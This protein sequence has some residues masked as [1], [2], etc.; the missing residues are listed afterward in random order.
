MDDIPDTYSIENV[1]QMRAIADR[2]RV[3]I[4]ELLAHR[5]MTVAQLSEQLHL[6]HAKVHYHVRELE[7]VGLVRLVETR[8]KGGILE[9][10]YRTVA[11]T[12]T[13]SPNL[14]SRGARDETVEIASQL[15]GKLTASFLRAL[16]RWMAKKEGDTTL[17]GIDASSLFL[18]EEEVSDLSR[19][20]N[21]L[22]EPYA[23]PRGIEGEREVTLVRLLFT[24]DDVEDEPAVAPSGADSVST[25]AE[26][27]Q[28]TERTPP[29]VPMPPVRDRKRVHTAITVGI[30]EYSRAD[31]EGFAA[32]GERLAIY[33]LGA[34]TFAEDVPADLVERVV[35]RT[36]IRGHLSAS[37]AVRAVIE[38]KEKEK[39]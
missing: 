7:Q 23:V 36:R 34:V 10:Y 16:G 35:R 19:R 33:A 15:L 27:D 32:R 14:L 25:G 11:K 31:L 30:T 38:R 17:A 8:E 4:V 39:E 26:P 18:T 2:L 6:A 12:I 13:V 3:R 24:D 1:E 28:P 21:S 5:P 9:K 29:A 22:L 37:P 20:M